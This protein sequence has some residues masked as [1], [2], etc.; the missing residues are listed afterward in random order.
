M[1]L[2]PLGVYQSVRPPILGIDNRDGG[3][4][5]ISGLGYLNVDLSIK[6][7][8]RIYE[9]Y[10][11]E[12]TGVLQNVMNHLDFASPSLSLQSTTNWGVTKTQGNAPRQIQMGVRAPH[13]GTAPVFRGRSFAF[14]MPGLKC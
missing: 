6:K 13:Q 11:L 5:V 7:S 14:A 12:F 9:K 1:F 10:S 2:D 4:G 8:L 3:V